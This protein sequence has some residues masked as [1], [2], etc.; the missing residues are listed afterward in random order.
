[1]E[2]LFPAGS[3]VPPLE[4]AR[5][6][7]AGMERQKQVSVRRTYVPNEYRVLLCPGDLEALAGV[8]A[9]LEREFGEYLSE[10]IEERGYSAQGRPRVTL[11]SDEETATGEVRVHA[12]FRE[13]TTCELE[14]HAGA[15][16]GRR[17]AIQGRAV[18][19]RSADADVALADDSVSRRHA[20]IEYDRGAFWVRDLGSTNGT[21]L[22]GESVK[23]AELEDGDLL[24]FGL[25]EAVFHVA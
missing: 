1:M 12:S 20:C 11:A 9:R 4:I 15:D 5:A 13:P 21:Y 8:Q 10:L 14:F 6:L 17:V 24:R 7:A 16:D 23:Q 2:G 18:V 22:N 3:G 19:G 25:A